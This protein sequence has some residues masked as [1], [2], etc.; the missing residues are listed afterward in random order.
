M[1]Y[2]LI[3]VAALWSA[4]ATSAFSAPDKPDKPGKAERKAEH[5]KDRIVVKV[6]GASR[7]WKTERE[8]RLMFSNNRKADKK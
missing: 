5:A 1:K 3:I 2:L 6:K 8:I 7:S 4:S